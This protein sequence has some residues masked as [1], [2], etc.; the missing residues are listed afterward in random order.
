MKNPRDVIIEPVISEKSYRLIESNKYVFLV[1]K[2]ANKEEIKDAVGSI[3]K[4][5]VT[6]VNTSTSKGKPKR[7]GYTSGRRPGYK[8]A[9]VTLAEGEKIEFF[10]TK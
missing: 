4:V 1:D 10:E 7:Q 8:K 9:I 2:R 5:R 6:G 3:F